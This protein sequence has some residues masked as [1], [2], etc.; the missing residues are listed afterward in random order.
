MKIVAILPFFLFLIY[1][2][3]IEENKV[4]VLSP[5]P[6]KSIKL[7][8]L[9]PGYVEEYTEKQNAL[10]IALEKSFEKIEKSVLNGDFEKIPILI[11]ILHSYQIK[12]VAVDSISNFYIKIFKYACQMNASE[13]VEKILE[14]KKDFKIFEGMIIA[15]L[16]NNFDLTRLIHEKL[17]FE[18]SFNW[19]KDF[20]EIIFQ[21][22]LKLRLKINLEFIIKIGFDL[23][24]KLWDCFAK[25]DTFLLDTPLHEYQ[26]ILNNS[27]DF[28]NQIFNIVQIAISNDF[29]IIIYRI[30]DLISSGQFGFNVF[31]FP[32]NIPF[33]NSSSILIQTWQSRINNP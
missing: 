1:S 5:K 12:N 17:H 10:V 24:G 8:I 9:K 13:L 7:L 22:I 29:N 6:L 15:E 23:N 33:Q 18:I 20:L 21:K 25:L 2:S 3:L 28:Y 14:Y 32:G 30:I 19:P 26:L 4:S 11:D 27:V 31:P 16:N